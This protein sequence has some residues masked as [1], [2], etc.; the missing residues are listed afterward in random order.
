[1]N[2][3]ATQFQA[4]Y[5]IPEGPSAIRQKTMRFQK[6]EVVYDDGEI[7]DE[8]DDGHGE[9]FEEAARTEARAGGRQG[10]GKHG[11]RKAE[12]TILKHSPPLHRR[13]FM[14]ASII[15]ID[16][17]GKKHGDATSCRSHGRIQG[18]A[19]EDLDIADAVTGPAVR[20][21]VRGPD[22]GVHR[23]EDQRDDGDD[24]ESACGDVAD[25]VEEPEGHNEEQDE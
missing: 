4:S 19:N 11:N 18:L 13:R 9:E 23:H 20:E 5:C 22:D 25:A 21:P 24:D 15:G 3:S 16:R 1:M 6:K 14:H 12:Q 7:Y 17:S 8:E 2:A 10:T